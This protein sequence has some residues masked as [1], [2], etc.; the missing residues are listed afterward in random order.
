MPFVSITVVQ[1]KTET[2]TQQLSALVHAAMIDTINCPPASLYHRISQVDRN[3]LMYLPEY[4]G[5]HRSDDVIIF[6]ITL[7]E[8]RTPEMK[9]AMYERITTDL[10][11]EMSIRPEDVII[12]LTENKAEDWFFGREATDS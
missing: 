8:G 6:Q 1:P 9:Q 10:R 2:F 11:R 12:V 5:L 7:K 4:K 3:S